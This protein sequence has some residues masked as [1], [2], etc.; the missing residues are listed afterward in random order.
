MTCSIVALVLACEHF[1]NPL[2]NLFRDPPAPG[3]TTT[4]DVIGHARRVRKIALRDRLALGA[5]ELF[6]KPF[7]QPVA[8]VHTAVEFINFFIEGISTNGHD[9][10]QTD[11]PQGAVF[12]LTFLQAD[13]HHAGGEGAAGLTHE[14]RPTDEG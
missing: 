14:Q 12:D 3:Y 1:L 6:H 4:L 13:G 10:K 8:A 9:G 11:D 7:R 2:R 5:A